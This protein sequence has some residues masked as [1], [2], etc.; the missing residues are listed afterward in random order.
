VA[1]LSLK[2]QRTLGVEL[3]FFVAS[4]ILVTSIQIYSVKMI[5]SKKFTKRRIQKKNV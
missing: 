4:S 5:P 2:H 3:D 1:I